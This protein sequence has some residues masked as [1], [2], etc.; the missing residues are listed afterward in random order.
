MEKKKT[1]L[2]ISLLVVSFLLVVTAGYFFLIN[3]TNFTKQGLSLIENANQQ[4]KPFIL[5][6]MSIGLILFGIFI[7]FSKRIKEIF[8][9]FLMD[10]LSLISGGLLVLGLFVPYNLNLRL[11][12][13]FSAFLI[14]FISYIAKEEVSKI[15]KQ[16]KT[17]KKLK[18]K[19]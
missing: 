11:A 17:N 12:L 4:I 19:Q 3:N 1:Y 16:N 15:F 18:W 5:W 9:I 13:I 14:Y 10:F 8:W 7:F 2:I 6:F